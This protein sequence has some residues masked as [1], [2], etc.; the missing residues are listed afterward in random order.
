MINIKQT[1]FKTK[2]NCETILGSWNSNY[3]SWKTLGKKVL[4]V[5][6]EDLVLK[7]KTTLLKIFRFL[8]NFGFNILNLNM[9][10]L[11]KSIKTTNFENMQKLEKIK[12]FKESV[13]N[14]KT[15]ERIPFFNLGP[16][17]D[18]RI[19]LDDKIRIKIEKVFRK[20]MEELGYL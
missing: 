14:P 3:N 18:W 8:E 16:K 7:K 15:G 4:I 5:K 13:F 9:Q 20:E 17:N 1:L 12:T 11:S 10:K 6:Y 19:D 2:E